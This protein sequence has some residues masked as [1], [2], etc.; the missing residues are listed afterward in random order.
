MFYLYILQYDLLILELEQKN[1][2]NVLIITLN[3]KCD[4][5]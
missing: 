5:K 2:S 3:K 4:Y 1:N